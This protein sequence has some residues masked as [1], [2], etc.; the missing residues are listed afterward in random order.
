MGKLTLGHLKKYLDNAGYKYNEKEDAIILGAKGEWQLFTFIRVREEGEFLNI[1]TQLDDPE[2][3]F[4]KVSTDNPYKKELMEYLLDENYKYKIG[5]W[6]VDKDDGDIRFNT[7]YHVEDG[8]LTQQ[9]FIRIIKSILSTADD[10]ALDITSILETGKTPDE[11]K[12]SQKA[13]TQILAKQV[14]ELIAQGKT[15]EAMAILNQLTEKK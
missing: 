10:A 9:Q 13:E 12:E 6:A 11:I 15:E 8:E 14:Q 4:L 2:G 5:S 3:N 7:H 1:N